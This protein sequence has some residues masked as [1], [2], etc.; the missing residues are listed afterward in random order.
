M[1]M[2]RTMASTPPASDL[3][4]VLIADHTDYSIE[5]AFL[6][7]NLPYA[8]YSDGT[9]TRF[10]VE[11][12]FMDLT[13]TWTDANSDGVLDGHSDPD[14]GPEIYIGRLRADNMGL[15]ETDLVNSYFQR[16]H[17]YR[18]TGSSLPQRAMS[19]NAMLLN[20]SQRL[21]AVYDN[22]PVAEHS[23]PS[24]NDFLQLLGSQQAELL[25]V[26]SDSGPT[27]HTF[28]TPT[29]TDSTPSPD[30]KNP[31]AGTINS[32]DIAGVS[33]AYH[34]FLLHACSAEDFTTPNNLASTYLLV[35]SQGLATFGVT[36]TTHAYYFDNY[37]ASNFLA[38]DQTLGMALFH[39]DTLFANDNLNAGDGYNAAEGEFYILGDPTLRL[40]SKSGTDLPGDEFS[41]NNDFQYSRGSAD[42]LGTIATYG[43]YYDLVYFTTLGSAEEAKNSGW[44]NY[45]NR[46]FGDYNDDLEATLQ[47]NDFVLFTFDG[48]EV[49]YFAEVAPDHGQ[50]DVFVDSVFQQTVNLQSATRMARQAVFYTS[51]AQSGRHSIML[52]NKIQGAY[53]VADFFWVGK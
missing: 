8:L 18:T 23:N 52:V 27:T 37:F 46:G 25:H 39:H 19:F 36:R 42:S 32:S 35:K 22:T 41:F 29:P 15:T 6:I 45:Q 2:V 11:Y 20:R 21:E 34:F 10:A 33:K 17:T 14:H 3:R 53:G 43:A 4:K 47:A 7:G 13:G 16:N 38:M 5:G 48:M 28:A 40:N 49:E 51:W 31:H 44:I 9:Y 50:M 30:P 26:I 12:Y 1:V 24:G